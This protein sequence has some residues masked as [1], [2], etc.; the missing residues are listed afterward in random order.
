MKVLDKGRLH[1]A[2]V[3]TGAAERMLAEA[4]AYATQR[5]QFG[6]PIADFQLVL[7]VK[8]AFAAAGS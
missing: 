2:S 4:L 8:I 3:A 5:R 7:L 6:Q 1:I